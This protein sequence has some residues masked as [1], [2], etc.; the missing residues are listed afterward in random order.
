MIGLVLLSLCFEIARCRLSTSFK[1]PVQVIAASYCENMHMLALCGAVR[2]GRTQLPALGFW[3]RMSGSAAAC[4]HAGA[5]WPEHASQAINDTARPTR[6]SSHQTPAT[7]SHVFAAQVEVLLIIWQY[8]GVL[9][10]QVHGG[11]CGT[12]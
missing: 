6:S 12:A 4:W 7:L 5:A 2:S 10:S 1:A 3:Q 9:V 11:I 8:P